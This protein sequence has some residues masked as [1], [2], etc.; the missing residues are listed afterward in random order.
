MFSNSINYKK[1]F[2]FWVPLALTWLL[3]SVEGPLIVAV[4]SRLAEPTYNLAA[5]GI[6]FAFAL[7][8]EAPIIMIMS[9]STALVKN[10]LTFTKLRNFT[11]AA[12]ALLTVMMLIFLIPPVF[13]F[14]TETLLNLPEEVSSLIH[15][16]TLL[17]LPWPGAIGYRRFYQGL[18]ISDNQT[19][20]V[21]MGTFIR[22]FFM[23]ATIFSLYFFTNLP[24][25]IV[26]ALALSAGVISEAAASKFMARQII[27]RLKNN[28]SNEITI[29]YPE[30]VKFYYPLALT[31]MLSLGVYPMVTFFLG[32]ARLSIESLAVL[33]VVNS[34]IFIFRSMGLSFQEVAIAMMGNDFKNYKK[35]RN[36]ATGIGAFV[37]GT[38]TLIG[39]TPLSDIWFSVISGLSPELSSLANSTLMLVTL[40]PGLSVLISFQRSIL[41]LDRNTKPLSYATAVEVIG[42]MCVLYITIH[43][44]D[45][46]GAY[47]AALAYLIG[48]LCANTFLIPPY[49]KAIRK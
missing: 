25:V 31:S 13:Y 30:I 44:F 17:L 19:V 16:E 9:A 7:I 29:S 37:V 32:Q 48:R 34:L 45:L 14:I 18:L 21:T 41:V 23:G 27:E 6:A 46:I 28:D 22:L 42:I 5:H 20:K 8:M 39:F 43:F 49:M 11:Y 24:G 12:N 35:L 1:I 4:I 33:P 15:I 2:F 38:L 10:R 26:G 47:A 3:M 40:L 36:F